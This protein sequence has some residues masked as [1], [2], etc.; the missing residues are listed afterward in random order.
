V[1]ARSQLKSQAGAQK[2]KSNEQKRESMKSPDQRQLNQLAG[3]GAGTCEAD[4]V[5]RQR[6]G[7]G[8]GQRAFLMRRR[9][10]SHQRQSGSQ[11]NTEDTGAERNEVA[12]CERETPRTKMDPPKTKK[13]WIPRSQRKHPSQNESRRHALL[14]EMKTFENLK[15]VKRWLR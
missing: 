15:S 14:Q 1:A 2:K 5:T 6:S 8:S 7:W 4:R 12:R 3:K 13:T 11:R 10:L 9:K